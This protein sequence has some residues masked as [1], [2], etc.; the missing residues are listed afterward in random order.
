[1]ATSASA[2]IKKVHFDIINFETK[3]SCLIIG[4][5]KLDRLWEEQFLFLF[6]QSLFLSKQ[7]S[8]GSSFSY[9]IVLC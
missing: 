9:L 7:G 6:C 3:L 2:S 5:I 4:S 1:M 8:E